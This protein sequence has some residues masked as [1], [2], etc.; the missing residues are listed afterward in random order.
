[1][2]ALYTFTNVGRTFEGPAED[3][4]LFHDL[5]FSV[6]RGECLAIVGASGSGKSTLLHLMGALDSPSHGTICYD[7]KD[8]ASM[9]QQE[10]AHFRNKELGFVFQFHHLLPEFS[11]EENVA[12]PALI[13]GI[14]LSAVLPKARE[15]LERVGLSHRMQSRITTLS[16]GERQRVAIARAILSEPRVLLAD[17]PTGNL[18]A[19]TGTQIEDLLLELNAELDTTLV[20]VTHNIQLAA[21]MGR[22]LALKGGTLEPVLL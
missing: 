20:I 4:C 2:T 21:R 19:L 15:M 17:E 14:S 7:G 5:T 18:D 9:T 12:M 3:V 8:L 22:C 11:A 13:G 10:K 1:M 16:G 6:E